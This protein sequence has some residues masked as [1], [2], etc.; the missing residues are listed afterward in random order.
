LDLLGFDGFDGHRPPLQPALS[1]S[2]HSSFCEEVFSHVA[3]VAALAVANAERLT[4]PLLQ[5]E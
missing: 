5:H 2:S 1:P 4:Q 3:F